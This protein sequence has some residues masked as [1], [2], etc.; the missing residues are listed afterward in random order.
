VS[1]RRL[2]IV[3]DVHAPRLSGLFTTE[4][5]TNVGG[6]A[7]MKPWL[8]LLVPFVILRAWAVDPGL[9]VNFNTLEFMMPGQP[10]P[11]VSPF[12]VD[13]HS[14]SLPQE[15]RYALWMFSGEHL[16]SS[17]EEFVWAWLF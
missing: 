3:Y 5:V 15:G 14:S 2:K 17:H 9:N 10:V 11:Q 13:G 16:G 7:D 1:Q 12:D 6:F 8:L 4:S